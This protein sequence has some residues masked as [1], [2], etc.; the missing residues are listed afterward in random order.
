MRFYLVATIT[1]YISC[2][3]TT[4]FGAILADHIP[5]SDKLEFVLPCFFFVLVIEFFRVHRS[6]LPLLFPICFAAISFWLYSSEY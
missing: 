2:V 6:S 1:V 4:L 5:V 3:L